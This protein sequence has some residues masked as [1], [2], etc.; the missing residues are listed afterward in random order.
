MAAVMMPSFKM[1][2][3]FRLRMTRMSLGKIVCEQ[4][5][6]TRRRRMQDMLMLTLRMFAARLD[7]PDLAVN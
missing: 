2:V 5:N 3:I 7:M 1:P 6:T 4:R